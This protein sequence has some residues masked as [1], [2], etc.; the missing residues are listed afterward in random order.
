MTK[1][2]G[3]FP[4][5]RLGTQADEF[6]IVRSPDPFGSVAGEP[7]FV[8]VVFAVF[9]VTRVDGQ[10]R[11]SDFSGIFRLLRNSVKTRMANTVQKS[12]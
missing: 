11:S 12:T 5:A 2:F 6:A 1:P 7:D 8:A 9:G 4:E 3:I 10:H